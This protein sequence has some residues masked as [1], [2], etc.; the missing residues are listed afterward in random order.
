LRILI[1]RIAVM[2]NCDGCEIDKSH[3]DYRFQNA[4]RGWGRKILTP[5]RSLSMRIFLS[6][7]ISC[8]CV[9]FAMNT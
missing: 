9:S 3:D 1:S 6:A 4:T 5:S 7:T 2:G 8:V